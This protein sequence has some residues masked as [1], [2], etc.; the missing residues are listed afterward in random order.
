MKRK[1]FALITCF[2]LC[3]CNANQIVNSGE[4][5][6]SE[7]SQYYSEA[8]NEDAASYV[9]QDGIP[10]FEYESHKASPEFLAAIMQYT[11]QEL[12]EKSSYVDNFYNI[13]G[14]ALYYMSKTDQGS[15][16]IVIQAPDGTAQTIFKST[17]A[18]DQVELIDAHRLQLV[19]IHQIFPEGYGYCYYSLNMETGN[20]EQIEEPPANEFK[21]QNEIFIIDL[22]EMS[23]VVYRVSRKSAEEPPL[24]LADNISDFRFY[25]DKLYYKV[26]DSSDLA[27]INFEG[28]NIEI[29][30][31]AVDSF[32]LYQNKLIYN[33]NSY[34]HI[35]DLNSNLD[36]KM[37]EPGW[38]YLNICFDEKGFYILKENSLFYIDY[39]GKISIMLQNVDMK[40]FWIIGDWVYYC[41]YKIIKNEK[42][43]PDTFSY[44]FYKV[45]LDGTDL[46]Q[47]D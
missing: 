2:M 44:Q 39:T 18:I 29:V 5:S 6:Q 26:I 20:V 27:S 46:T 4:H 33:S 9:W 35:L 16:K 31:S 15:S 8:P 3:G 1:I 22:V 21:W 24:L 11:D 12:F 28:K 38:S 30:C 17:Q 19:I 42:Y 41:N 7:Q 14:F 45:K 36:I 37:S 43:G 40:T 13:D 23:P 34:L 25:K 32:Q 10:A 47:L